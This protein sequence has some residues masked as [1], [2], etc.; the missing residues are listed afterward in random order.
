MTRG[1]GTKKS[2]FLYYRRVFFGTFQT[3]CVCHLKVFWQHRVGS[4]VTV[5]HFIFYCTQDHHVYR[6]SLNFKSNFSVVS[7]NFSVVSPKN[8]EFRL[9]E[10][11]IRNSIVSQVLIGVCHMK[12]Y[13]DKKVY[14]Q[15][16]SELVLTPKKWY[17][18]SGRDLF[19][20]L[21]TRPV[22]RVFHGYRLGMITH[23]TWV[24]VSHESLCSC[25]ESLTRCCDNKFC[26]WPPDLL[27]LLHVITLPPSFLTTC[28]PHSYTMWTTNTTSGMKRG[29]KT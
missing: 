13:V 19:F 10:Q 4:S 9:C 26:C 27:V 21:V 18:I 25:H 17:E 1:S 8:R 11:G 5:K 28:I 24:Y 6:L 16:Y 12:I 20:G 2:I 29:V 7:P 22:W 3:Q 15:L 14:R 23:R